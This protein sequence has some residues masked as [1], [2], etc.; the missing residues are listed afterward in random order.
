MR[1][2]QIIIIF[3]QLPEISYGI[4]IFLNDSRCCEGVRR[5]SCQLSVAGREQKRELR[6]P[7]LDPLRPEDE[8]EYEYDFR[9]DCE[10]RASSDRT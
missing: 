4:L 10:E 3:R 6:R 1:I 8:I 2:L 5:F 7:I 9:N